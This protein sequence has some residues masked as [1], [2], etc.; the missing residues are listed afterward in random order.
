MA[1]QG[2]LEKLK[3]LELHYE[4]VHSQLADPAVY[5]DREKLIHGLREMGL[6]AEEVHS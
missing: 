3:A 4:E 5:A 1:E 6:T 2:M